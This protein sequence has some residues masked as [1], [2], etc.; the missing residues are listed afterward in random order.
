MDCLLWHL[1]LVSEGSLF[2][3][4]CFWSNVFCIGYS[5]AERSDWMKWCQI[6]GGLWSRRLGTGDAASRIWLG[7]RSKCT[8]HRPFTWIQEQRFTSCLHRPPDLFFLC[9]F[10]RHHLVCFTDFCTV[11]TWKDGRPSR[12]RKVFPVLAFKL[13]CVFHCSLTLTERERIRCHCALK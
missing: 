11:S 12:G 4:P 13:V 8:D 6:T 1:P 7:I 10:W 5:W 2:S 9:F 3:L